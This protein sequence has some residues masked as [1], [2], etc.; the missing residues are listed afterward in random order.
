VN[1]LLSLDV[2][3]NATVRE[4]GGADEPEWKF[5]MGFCGAAENLK[6]FGLDLETQ[7]D[8][9]EGMFEG[10][11]VIYFCAIP[12]A[13]EKIHHEIEGVM[14]GVEGIINLMENARDRGIRRI[15]ISSC[16]CTIRGDKYKAH[17]NEEIWNTVNGAD[18]SEECKI[19]A[20]R[21]AWWFNSRHPDDFDLTIFNPGMLLGPSL[22]KKRIKGASQTLIHK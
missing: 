2:K 18:F 6:V 5:L 19:F 7:E 12:N 4:M 17:Y 22:F 9:P 13:F 20:E 16:V 15:V 3:V 10:V 1:L 14:P 11:D 8:W 21:T